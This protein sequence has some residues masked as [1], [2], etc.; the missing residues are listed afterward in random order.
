MEKIIAF[1]CCLILSLLNSSLILA[2]DTSFQLTIRYDFNKL[3]IYVEASPEMPLSLES[4]MIEGEPQS[5]IVELLLNST[6][7]ALTIKDIS[8]PTCL[9][10]RISSR[11]TNLVGAP[12]ECTQENRENSDRILADNA[13]WIDN[14]LLRALGAIKIHYNGAFQRCDNPCRVTFTLPTPIPTIT[15]LA[16]LT[17]TPTYTPSPT[18]TD[19][20]TL[21][22]SPLFPIDNDVVYIRHWIRY[23]NQLQWSNRVVQGE[24]DIFGNNY[25]DLLE[26]DFSFTSVD[27]E[28]PLANDRINWFV[29]DAFCQAQGKRLPT[30]DELEE[31]KETLSEED[32][33]VYPELIEWT[34]TP[35]LNAG[36]DEKKPQFFKLWVN[37]DDPE[38]IYPDLEFWEDEQ[39]GGYRYR[40]YI[41]SQTLPIG[42]RCFEGTE[43]D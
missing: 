27:P 18:L 10:L 11:P 38:E 12:S 8:K 22:P 40:V 2:Q 4:L 9:I 20:L 36:D 3:F 25:G 21:T 1:C 6:Y 30:I 28:L 5:G 7:D 14:D 33:V 26:A 17:D 41:V 24:V 43:S 23:S 32:F 31:A 13:P 15:P 42:F 35:S 37:A 29:A 34:R 16:T 39:D 19:T